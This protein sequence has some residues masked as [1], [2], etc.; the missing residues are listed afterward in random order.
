MN[1]NELERARA[2]LSE[3]IMRYLQSAG[4]SMED[5][6]RTL[7]EYS[8]DILNRLKNEFANDET[9]QLII[10]TT[11]RI[12]SIINNL[13]NNLDELDNKLETLSAE[14]A[15]TS[16]ERIK[17]DLQDEYNQIEEQR[18]DVRKLLSTIRNQ[19]EEEYEEQKRHLNAKRDLD[20]R[21]EALRSEAITKYKEHINNITGIISRFTN[22]FTQTYNTAINNVTAIY[23]QS[24]GKLAAMLD[25]TVT[26]VSRLQTNIARQLT[27]ANLSTA[28]SNVEVLNEAVAMA[29]AGFTNES[30]LQQSA[31]DI[32]IG[33]RIAPTIDFSSATVKNLVNVFGSDFT[34]KFAAIAQ[35][36][37]DTAGST[38]GLRE[39]LNTLTTDLEPVF[40]N[41]ELQSAALQ[42]TADVT[43]TLAAAQEQGLL[44]TKDVAQ[45]RQL[46]VE[47]MDPSKAFTSSNVAVRMAATTD[48]E[49]AFSG[50]PARALQALL[51]ARQQLYGNVSGDLSST[52]NMMRGIYASAMG[53]T[54]LTAAYMPEAYT[55]VEMT[56]ASDLESVYSE[57]LG[58]LS[59]NAYTT[60]A[61][62]VKNAAEN[63]PAVQAISKFSESFPRT[64]TVMSQL[65]LQEIRNIPKNI[66]DRYTRSLKD[67]F[68]DTSDSGGGK[69]PGGDGKTPSDGT[70]GGWFSRTFRDSSGRLRNHPGYRTSGAAVSS[71]LAGAAGAMTLA[72]SIATGEGAFMGG[73][74]LTS[75]LSYGGIGASIG[76]IIGGG[77]LG[78]AIGALGGAAVG[79]VGALIQQ[80][81]ATKEQTKAQEE[82]TKTMK[83]TFGSIEYLSESQ[84]AEATASGGGYLTL[85]NGKSAAI[86]TAY[87]KNL[88]TQGYATG[89]DYVPYDDYVVRLHKGEAV[90]TANAARK[91]RENNPNFWNSP[92]D[93]NVVDELE[94]QTRSIVGAIN[95]EK[96]MSPL[97]QQGLS[98]QYVIQNAF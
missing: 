69:L 66:G 98:K 16:N 29:S 81:Q 90:V 60:A 64:Y 67:A 77:P 61:E 11:T 21:E 12:N 84:K 74:W 44:T 95:G 1:E 54:A 59:D 26:D 8:S 93:N 27:S 30:T 75:A 7:M 37:Q 41:A 55:Q 83:D 6:A 25:S 10:D 15:L 3:G 85:S 56:T 76:T 36:T 17:Q 20:E 2:T 23:N 57:Q 19:T 50:D 71:Y 13:K 28:I 35:A 72:S 70:S 43:A 45:Y 46:L 91:L 14:I 89:L 68:K 9:A 62:K 73:D 53:D 18:N 4:T 33:K 65:I 58:K 86:D 94:K 48:T 42:G 47:L 38:V 78:T 92:Y 63:N 34:T 88:Q 24:A 51:A 97:T 22:E 32:A 82:Q 87:Y 39:T 96:E 80:Q 31:T 52:N 49:A 40:L 79:L 5:I